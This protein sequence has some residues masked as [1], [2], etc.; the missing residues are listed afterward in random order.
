MSN[1]NEFTIYCSN[2]DSPI[3]GVV[4]ADADAP[5]ENRIR[6][7]CPFC[8][9]HSFWKTFSGTYCFGG[10]AMPNPKDARDEIPL[11]R[12]VDDEWDGDSVTYIMARENSDADPR[13]CRA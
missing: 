8:G 3:A 2:C 1:V 4:I 13:Q 9:D 12:Y 5:V 10:V 6:A 11:T 7:R